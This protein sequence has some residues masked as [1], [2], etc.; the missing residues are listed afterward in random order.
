MEGK[1]ITTK[2]TLTTT[3]ILNNIGLKPEDVKMENIGILINEISKITGKT[4]EEVSFQM[5]KSI[6]E[7]EQSWEVKERTID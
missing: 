4:Q 5:I 2:K 3:K 7:G 1:T 6:Y